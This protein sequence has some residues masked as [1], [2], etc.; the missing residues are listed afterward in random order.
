MAGV[1]VGAI[2]G[3]PSVYHIGAHFSGMAGAGVSQGPRF[4]EATGQPRFPDPASICPH[5]VEGELKQWHL[6]AP[7]TLE[8][9]AQLPCGLAHFWGLFLYVLIA[10]LNCGWRRLAPMLTEAAGQPGCPDS[11]LVYT[12]KMEGEI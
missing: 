1:V 12:I 4:A 9:I 2:Q 8:S 5:K 7:L 10:L 11:G 3:C 6:P